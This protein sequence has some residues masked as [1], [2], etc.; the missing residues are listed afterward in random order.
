MSSYFYVLHPLSQGLPN[1][2][3]ISL[4]KESWSQPYHV[5][6]I[7]PQPDHAP[8][9]FNWVYFGLRIC[10]SKFGFFC[11]RKCFHAKFLKLPS[12]SNH[13]NH[14]DIGSK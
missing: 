14:F 9:V 5:F 3:D 10:E 13:K 12:Y 6:L 1:L 7:A 8:Q 4:E 2:P 11:T